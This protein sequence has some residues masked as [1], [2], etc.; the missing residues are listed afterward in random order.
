MEYEMNTTNYLDHKFLKNYSIEK[1]WLTYQHYSQAHNYSK[2]HVKLWNSID[3]NTA[4]HKGSLQQHVEQY[5]HVCQW[6]DMMIF[7]FHLYT[8]SLGTTWVSTY[9]TFYSN[10]TFIQ[11]S[12]KFYL[13]CFTNMINWKKKMKAINFIEWIMILGV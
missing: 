4:K 6:N 12:I 10:N 3:D 5:C 13:I 9:Q 1:W 11:L 8:I 2:K 7:T